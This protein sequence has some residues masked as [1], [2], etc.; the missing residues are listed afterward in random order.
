MVTKKPLTQIRLQFTESP[1]IMM[2]LGAK[3]CQARILCLCLV[4]YV[5]LRLN[6]NALTASKLDKAAS[7]KKSHSQ[8]R[9]PEARHIGTRIIKKLPREATIRTLEISYAP[10]FTR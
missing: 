9:L 7:M 5:H 6:S 3:S 4:V 2:N 8:L 10:S 1:D